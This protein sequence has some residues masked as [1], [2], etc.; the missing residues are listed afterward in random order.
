[1]VGGIANV[2][3]VVVS[4]KPPITISP[5]YV[6]PPIANEPAKLL[7]LPACKVIKSNAQ[8]LVFIKSTP[9]EF[10][11]FTDKAGAKPVPE[12]VCLVFPSNDS[13]PK[14]TPVVPGITPAIEPL[15]NTFPR[16]VNV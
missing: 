16:T 3:G 7:T 10:A 11:I 9:A 14:P 5:L 2:P 8:A 15:F 13:D 12:T 1:M 4:F 6:A